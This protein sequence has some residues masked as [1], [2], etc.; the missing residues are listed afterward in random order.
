MT[1]KPVDVRKRPPLPDITTLVQLRPKVANH[2]TVSW[3]TECGHDY[4]IAVHLVKRLTSSELLRRLKIRGVRHSD[5][6]RVLSKYIEFLGFCGG[7]C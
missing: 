2:I 4:A 1:W 7:C 6:T 5:F 3:N